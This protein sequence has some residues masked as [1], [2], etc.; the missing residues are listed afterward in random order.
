MVHRVAW[1]VCA[2]LRKYTELWYLSFRVRSFLLADPRVKFVGLRQPHPLTPSIELRIQ[3][4]Q[5]KNSGILRPLT[6]V[7]SVKRY[8]YIME[9]SG[10]RQ[11]SN[12]SC[13]FEALH[14]LI[15]VLEYTT[16][17]TALHYGMSRYVCQKNGRILPNSRISSVLLLPQSNPINVFIEAAR[18]QKTSLSHLKAK[19]KAA[20]D[21]HSNAATG[22]P[23]CEALPGASNTPGGTFGGASLDGAAVGTSGMPV[24]Q[25]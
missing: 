20:V 8:D 3:T 11:R 21:A 24:S 12:L 25:N 14:I 16:L 7:V 15:E 22:L 10:P 19:F 2:K 6:R 17:P 9:V 1:G 5:V 23:T 13:A 18:R 4:I